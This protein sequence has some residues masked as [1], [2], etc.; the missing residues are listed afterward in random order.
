MVPQLKE[1]ATF[2]KKCFR[3]SE[4]IHVILV[5]ALACPH[6]VMPSQC[7][8][9]VSV[10]GAPGANLEQH[11]LFFPSSLQMSKQLL[12][13]NQNTGALL[14]TT[15]STTVW[16]KRST[17]RPPVCWWMVS[18]IRPTIRTASALACSPT[19]T[20]IPLLKTPGDIL[21]KV[22]L[23]FT[24]LVNVRLSFLKKRLRHSRGKC[25]VSVRR[26]LFEEFFKSYYL[27]IVLI[28][29]LVVFQL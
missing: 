6:C 28:D 3:I 13:R 15:S 14:C 7:Y 19:L 8:N 25:P 4:M 10:W 21:G 17:P 20:G 11:T 18:Q 2:N 27:E 12:M 24:R 22:S 16:V 1:N 26:L 5:F 9:A 23:R 29:D